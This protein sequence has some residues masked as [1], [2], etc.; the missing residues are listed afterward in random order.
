[1]TKPQYEQKCKECKGTPTRWKLC[2]VHETEEQEIH[3]RWAA[4][5]RARQPQE[6]MH[7]Q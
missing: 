4:E 6:Q 2:P 1:M 5:H 3:Q 7:G